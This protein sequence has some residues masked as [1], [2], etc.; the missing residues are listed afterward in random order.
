M[1]M[2]PTTAAANTTPSP[3]REID[4]WCGWYRRR[5]SRKWLN[6]GQAG[7]VG[8]ALRLASEA[9]ELAGYQHRDTIALAPGRDPNRRRG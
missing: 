2:T 3:A 4:G 8:D 6:A 9:A 1:T 7:T 5:G